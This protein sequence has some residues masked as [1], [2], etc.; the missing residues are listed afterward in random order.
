VS[1]LIAFLWNNKHVSHKYPLKECFSPKRIIIGEMDMERQY[2]Y[3]RINEERNYQDSLGED[4]T[5]G[6]FRSVGDELVLM[7]VYLRRAFDAWANNP[8]D[9]KALDEVRKIAA[10]T[11]RC[12][13]NHG[14]P[15]R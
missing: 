7:E 3:D 5:D 9:M 15:K 12:L 8:G 11:V 2:V 10:I 6:H 4:R 14:A 1:L 13:E